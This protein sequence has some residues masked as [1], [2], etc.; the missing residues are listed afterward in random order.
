MD[1]WMKWMGRDR[2]MCEVGG[3]IEGCMKRGGGNGR[4]YEVDGE[5][6]RDV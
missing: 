3:G 4:T 2:G 1:G 6:W 5:R